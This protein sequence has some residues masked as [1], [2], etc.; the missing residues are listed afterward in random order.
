MAKKR[1]RVNKDTVGRSAVKRQELK[2]KTSNLALTPWRHITKTFRFIFVNWKLFLPL[3]LVALATYAVS[4]CVS[5]DAMIIIIVFAIIMLWLATMFFV[6]RVMAGEKVKFRDGLYNAMTPLISTLMIFV[7]LVIQCL[8]IMLLVIGYSAAIETHLFGNMF[9][10]SL[11][12]LFAILMVV[13]SGYL[14][15]GTLMALISVSTPGMYPLTALELTHELMMG[16]RL[17]FVLR[18]VVLMVA[19]FIMGVVLVMPVLLVGLALYNFGGIETP[20]LV[21]IMVTVVA[22]FAVIYAGVYLY[23]YYRDLLGMDASK[24]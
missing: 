9:Y 23:I 3:V 13:V 11:F 6:R 17:A 4:F 24:K 18:I 22:F 10:G 15:S 2:D 8:P 5:E 21:P 12:V 1:S 19:I 7:V 16:K 20:M 14:L